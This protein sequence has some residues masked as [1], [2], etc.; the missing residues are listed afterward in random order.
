MLHVH[1]VHNVHNI[2]RVDSGDLSFLCR[3][4]TAVRAYFAALLHSGHIELPSQFVDPAAK[5][6]GQL[7]AISLTVT[8]WDQAER[9][10]YRANSPG[11]QFHL[12]TAA[13]ENCSRV[14][15]NF[16]NVKSIAFLLVPV[17]AGQDRFN[18]NTARVEPPFRP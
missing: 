10:Y 18:D 3:V 5:C 8:L 14:L 6:I 9:S 16:S 12:F 7:Q 4:F 17:A 13:L 2:H 1:N 15:G 11:F